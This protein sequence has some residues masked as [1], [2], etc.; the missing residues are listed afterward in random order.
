M[1]A[2][3]RIN[4][5][6]NKRSPSKLIAAL[7]T[8][9][10]SPRPQAEKP[11]VTK[12]PQEK[13]NK[14][15]GLKRNEPTPENNNVALTA[16][17][18]QMMAAKQKPQ[19]NTTRNASQNAATTSVSLRKQLRVENIKIE[20]KPLPAVTVPINMN[21]FNPLD[22]ILNEIDAF[23]TSNKPKKKKQ[24]KSKAIKTETFIELEEENAPS[25]SQQLFPTPISATVRP[26]NRFELMRLEQDN[27]MVQLFLH[28]DDLMERILAY[29]MLRGRVESYLT[30]KS[31]ID[32][33]SCLIPEYETRPDLVEPVS[34]RLHPK[35]EPFVKHELERTIISDDAT[36]TAT[37]ENNANQRIGPMTPPGSPGTNHSISTQHAQDDTHYYHNVQQCSLNEEV[38]CH[39]TGLPPPPMQ[40]EFEQCEQAPSTSGGGEEM[41]K[42][43][44]AAL[45]VSEQEMR[46][47]FGSDLQKLRHFKAE[48]LLQTF[49]DSVKNLANRK[50][51]KPGENCN[52]KAFKS[53]T[54]TSTVSRAKEECL[55][56]H[57]MA[58]NNSNNCEMEAME[59]SSESSSSSSASQ[60]FLPPPPAPPPMPFMVSDSDVLP[61]PPPPLPTVEETTEEIIPPPPP[62]PASTHTFKH[63]DDHRSND[64]PTAAHPERS[65][66]SATIL[67][68]HPT[69]RNQQI[70]KHFSNATNPQLRTRRQ[71]LERKKFVSPARDTAGTKNARTNQNYYN[72]SR[73][74]IAKKH[75]IVQE[76]TEMMRPP[77][78]K[79]ISMDAS[80]TAA[81]AKPV[82][83][84]S[85]HLKAPVSSS[86]NN[87]LDNVNSVNNRSKPIETNIIVES[88][89]NTLENSIQMRPIQNTSS[90]TP[91]STTQ[92]GIIPPNFTTPLPPLQTTQMQ[93]N[94]PLSNNKTTPVIPN[95]D[96]I[97]N[98][99]PPAIPMC[100]RNR[101]SSTTASTTDHAANSILHGS[102][103]LGEPTTHLLPRPQSLLNMDPIRSI[104]APITTSIPPPIFTIPPPPLPQMINNTSATPIIPNQS[105]VLQT[106]VQAI[107]AGKSTET[108]GMQTTRNQNNNSQAP[109]AS[110]AA[111]ALDSSIRYG[112][113][114]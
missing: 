83:L 54:Q 93:I 111:M 57:L 77:K 82:S 10:S 31:K 5:E 63:F 110:S 56:N 99:P 109:T 64:A 17:R 14:K 44:V 2:P 79:K 51:E 40:P 90:S 32:L 41:I 36:V 69:R 61:P 19:P 30:M 92:F 88:V 81:C 73:D 13:S 102:S 101:L 72:N 113:Y 95:M 47:M 25:S 42:K 55:S 89:A 74:K 7:N 33:N 86:A 52:S 76:A 114:Y 21:G 16:K 11:N 98:T 71:N 34:Q 91:P 105:T 87:I 65:I 70:R 35:L 104:T 60:L 27:S 6:K 75:N 58:T 49:R 12:T 97:K 66:E 94:T 43:F 107:A 46:K 80:V 23:D 59:I 112:R 45:G 28:R 26:L 96:F 53:P 20:E 8:P 106:V 84:L 68:R 100:I 37:T 38:S 18:K 85:L 29:K 22:N 67:P 1:M 103:I 78:Y 108:G 9:T 50:S 3:D 39:T 4:P 24:T 48:D 15:T 62:P